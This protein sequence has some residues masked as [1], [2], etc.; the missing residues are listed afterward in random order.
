MR[1]FPTQHMSKSLV[2]AVALITFSSP[3]ALPQDYTNATNAAWCAGA[4][5]QVEESTRANESTQTQQVK[6]AEEEMISSMVEP[7][8]QRHIAFALGYFA[9]DPEMTVTEFAMF[10]RKAVTA[11]NEDS[12]RCSAQ[13]PSTLSDVQNHTDAWSA[14]TTCMMK[15]PDCRRLRACYD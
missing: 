14:F 7:A 4:L 12:R 5:T 13:H 15:N 2:L 9:N 11:C 3:R 1:G 10:G 6:S 8:R